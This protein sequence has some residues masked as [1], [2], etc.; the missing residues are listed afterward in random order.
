MG[1]QIPTGRLVGRQVT[2]RAGPRTPPLSILAAQARLATNRRL[3][4]LFVGISAPG[5]ALGLRRPASSFD[6]CASRKGD[7]LDLRPWHQISDPAA[8]CRDALIAANAPVGSL[9][10]C[11]ENLKAFLDGVLADFDGSIPEHLREAVTGVAGIELR[12]A[13]EA[14]VREEAEA[15]TADAGVLAQPTCPVAL[16]RSAKEGREALIARQRF[17]AIVE[18]GLHATAKPAARTLQV[19]R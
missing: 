12:E 9:R 10:A 13:F 8:A 7:Y 5:S 11:R 3:R 2:Q 4:R 15:V 16:E 6:A 17:L 14:A 19:A 18:G 1:N